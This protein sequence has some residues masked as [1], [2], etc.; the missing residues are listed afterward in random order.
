[1]FSPLNWFFICLLLIIFVKNKR[2]KHWISWLAIIIL[3][4]FSS[5]ALFQ[6][7]ARWWQP[8][9]VEL[10]EQSHYSYAIVAGGF[11]SVDADG[12]GYFNSSSDRF[13]QAVKLYHAGTVDHIL[14]SGGNSKRNDKNFSEGAWA[15][16]EM[17]K[18]GV[19]ANL[20]FV[21]DASDGTKAN[22]ANSKRILD[23]LHAQPPFVLITSA[24]HIPRATKIFKNEGLQVLPYPCNYTEGRGPIS[25][26][27]LVPDFGVMIG[28]SKY[29]KE[30]LWWIIKG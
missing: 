19:P 3:M 28:W 11:G 17:T 22:A 10:P 6:Y 13:L 21:E 9:P 27:D 7:Y 4:V 15:K 18:M 30:T 12:E 29:I 20:I 5:P 2:W 25:A 1:M 26:K 24:F 14:I 16:S 23:S 8:K